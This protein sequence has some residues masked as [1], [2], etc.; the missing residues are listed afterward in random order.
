MEMETPGKIKPTF[1]MLLQF[2]CFSV[3]RRQASLKLLLTVA[4]QAL[5]KTGGRLQNNSYLPHPRRIVSQLKE[6]IKSVGKNKSIKKKVPN[7]FS[8]GGGGAG[9][10]RHAC[11]GGTKGAL[12]GCFFGE[13]GGLHIT[14]PPLLLLSV[15]PIPGFHPTT[16]GL[17]HQ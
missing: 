17:L 14:P 9:G 1:V 2:F 8:T 16:V 12:Q 13:V 15:Q 3:A 10:R 6:A 11:S 5:N 7:L 4:A